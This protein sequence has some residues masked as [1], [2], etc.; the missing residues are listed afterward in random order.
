M[1]ALTLLPYFGTGLPCLQQVQTVSAKN[2][3]MSHTN[4]NDWPTGE[5][6]EILLSP[7]TARRHRRSATP[8]ILIL[9]WVFGHGTRCLIL[10]FLSLFMLSPFLTCIS[11]LFSLLF[12]SRSFC[13]SL[14][15]IF[16]LMLIPEQLSCCSGRRE[17]RCSQGNVLFPRLLQD[18]SE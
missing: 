15:R 4:Q 13:L 1:I 16:C 12:L 2:I 8:K 5:K 10:G 11:L 7:W 17:H 6:W 14:T 3:R 9:I 18:A